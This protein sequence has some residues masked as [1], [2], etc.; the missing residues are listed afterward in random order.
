M[1]IKELIN[2]NIFNTLKEGSDLN[3]EISG[4]FN[5]DLLSIAMSKAPTDCAW[6]TVMGNIN[7]LA[8]ATLADVSCVILA[9]GVFFDDAATIRL[10]AT[11]ITV[12]TTEMPVFE[13]SLKVYE[14]I[15]A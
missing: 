6:V 15:N 4:L 5:C 10:D 13:A 1:T 14:M 12:F 9:E 7:T 8:V 2:A 3:R 11:D